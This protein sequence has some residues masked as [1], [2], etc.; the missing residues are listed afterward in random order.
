MNDKFLII[1]IHEQDKPLLYSPANR[2]EII[3]GYYEVTEKD[4]N[5]Q[6]FLFKNSKKEIKKNDR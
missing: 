4:Y 5:Q 1:F 3:E 6:L 2:E